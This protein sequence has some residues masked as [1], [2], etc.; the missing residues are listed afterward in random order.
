MASKPTVTMVFEEEDRNTH[1]VLPTMSSLRTKLVEVQ[2]AALAQSLAAL[3]ND[4][5]EIVD[6][7]SVSNPKANLK[8]IVIA[9]QFN[10]EGGIAWI[11]SAKTGVSNGMTLTF[12]ILS[13]G[14]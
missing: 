13:R 8:Q 11:G 10:A 2:K 4:M 6:T 5:N 9:V 1:Q 14:Q 7:V 12:E 3:A